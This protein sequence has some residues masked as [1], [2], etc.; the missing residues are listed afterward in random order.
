[1][2]LP[3]GIEKLNSRM[4]VTKNTRNSATANLQPIQ[5]LSPAENVSKFPYTPNGVSVFS[6]KGS[7][8]LSGRNF[9]ASGPHTSGFR[10]YPQHETR[11]TVP[12]GIG[13]LWCT[14]P[15]RPTI[16]LVR[17]K[18]WSFHVTLSISIA[19]PRYLRTSYMSVRTRFPRVQIGDVD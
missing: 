18:T 4:S 16:G 19:A 7:S 13:K 2:F 17:G 11:T 3:S 9:I 15:D 5:L 14:F 12:F 6:L 10:L 1:M 8:H